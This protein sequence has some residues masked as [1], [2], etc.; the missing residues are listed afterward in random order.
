MSIQPVEKKEIRSIYNLATGT[1]FGKVTVY[2]QDRR[3]TAVE[4]VERD[5]V[6]ADALLVGT[7]QTW[8]SGENLLSLAKHEGH[9]NFYECGLFAFYN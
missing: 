3:V 9:T 8:Y 2:M 6:E 4:G 5:R 1:G 7:G